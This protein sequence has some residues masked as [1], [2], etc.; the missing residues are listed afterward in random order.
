MSKTHLIDGNSIGYAAH[1]ATR[2][3]S[4][5]LE[6]QSVFGFIKTLR[7]LRVEQPDFTPM[8]LWDGH[9][10]WRYDLHPGYKEK[11]N[12]DPKRV[13]SREAYREARPFIQRALSALGVRQISAKHHEADDLAGYFV[14]L[15]MA[16][17]GNEIE[18]ISGD[19]DWIQLLR[20]GVSWRD[21]RD[22]TRFVHMGNL[23][24]KT[25]YTTPYAF[26]EGK[27]LQGDASDNI[28]GVGGIG[29]KGAPVLLAE[30]G[31]IRKLWQSVDSGAFKPK[32]KALTNLCSA[33]GRMDFGRNLR[34]MQLLKVAP[35]AKSDV[36]VSVGKFDKDAFADLCGELAFSSILKHLDVFTKPFE[37]TAA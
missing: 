4:G 21:L 25:G 28:P 27:C 26:L 36:D 34:L 37:R 12:T 5:G 7:N 32:S 3:T 10:Q 8:V 11:R 23:L 2:L 19:Q 22:D 9:A 31:S 13:A 20:Q 6:T 15:L 35:P 33:Q 1:N 18:L 24:D 29:E 14:P 30:H 16:R 17:P